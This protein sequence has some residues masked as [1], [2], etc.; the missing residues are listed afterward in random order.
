MLLPGLLCFVG[1]AMYDETTRA[2]IVKGI[3]LSSAVTSIFVL[4]KEKESLFSFGAAFVGFG[5][6]C[7]YKI[8]IK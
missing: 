2:K 6:G 3:V 8:T 4:R 7:V 1:A 5:L